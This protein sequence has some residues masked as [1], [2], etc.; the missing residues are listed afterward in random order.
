MG[1]FFFLS[2]LTVLHHH[3][4]GFLV[5]PCLLSLVGPSESAHR[6][7][8]I[9]KHWHGSAKRTIV[10]LFW[11]IVLAHPNRREI[12]PIIPQPKTYLVNIQRFNLFFLSTVSQE[13]PPLL[14]LEMLHKI[15]DIFLEY[16]QKISE[17]VIRENFSLVYQ[18]LDEMVDAGLPFTTEGNQLREMILPPTGMYSFP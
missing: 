16:M 11:E 6:E 15:V 13:A 14:I 4:P 12:R 8:L 1:V 10:D 2:W 17:T 9:E 3:L 18:L 5:H 7:V